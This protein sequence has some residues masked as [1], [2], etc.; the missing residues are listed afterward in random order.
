MI[1]LNCSCT[2]SGQ[3]VERNGHTASCNRMTRKGAKVKPKKEA[4]PIP[5]VSPKMAAALQI[6]SNKKKELIEGKVCGVCGLDAKDI[7]HKKGRNTIELL[8]DERY[9]LF[10]CRH[11]HSIIENR[12]LWAKEFGYSLDRL[13]K[14]TL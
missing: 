11:C 5:K 2:E 3:P 7:H 10:V 8:L 4:K 12:P 13:A 14:P 1:P 9:W 6:Y